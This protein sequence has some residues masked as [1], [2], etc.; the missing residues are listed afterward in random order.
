MP[1][2]NPLEKSLRQPGT[3]LI[4]QTDCRI[5]VFAFG[6]SL[7]LF[8]AIT[9]VLCVGFDLMFPGMAMY[10]S[11]MRFLPGFTWLSW[12]SFALGLI[13]SYAYGWYV[14]LVLG[15]LFNFFSARSTGVIKS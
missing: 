13:E 14:A 2:P 12:P 15:P 10:E 8:L 3:P 5:P 1:S 4:G 11:W 6:M 7:G 9:F